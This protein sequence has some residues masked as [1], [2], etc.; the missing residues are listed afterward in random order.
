MS[1]RLWDFTGRYRQVSALVWTPSSL[2]YH[3]IIDII[4][5]IYSVQAD[6]Y[7]ISLQQRIH[8]T[9]NKTFGYDIYSLYLNKLGIAQALVSLFKLPCASISSIFFILLLAY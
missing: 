4:T 5:S 6:H 8:T 3:G 2:G 1:G 9:D 7:I